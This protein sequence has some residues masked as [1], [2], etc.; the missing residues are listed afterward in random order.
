M[1]TFEMVVAIANVPTFAGILVWIIKVE[2]RLIK[3]ETICKLRNT[4]CDAEVK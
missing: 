1:T 3:I 2:T 4:I